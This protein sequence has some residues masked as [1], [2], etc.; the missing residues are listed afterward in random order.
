MTYGMDHQRD[1][2]E[3]VKA[4]HLSKAIK[5]GDYSQLL[6][7]RDGNGVLRAQS[8]AG[9]KYEE[10]SRKREEA[11][12]RKPLVLATASTRSFE[13]ENHIIRCVDKVC[14]F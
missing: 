5:K 12:K 6:L 10:N 2:M 8:K 4:E 13:D 9:V 14:F 7:K 11:E 1:K 3:Y